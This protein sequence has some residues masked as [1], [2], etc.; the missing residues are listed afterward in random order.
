MG[1]LKEHQLWGEKQCK[2][3]TLNGVRCEQP[4]YRNGL[5]FYCSKLARKLTTPDDSR[6]KS[7]NFR[8]WGWEK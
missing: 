7:V 3:Q 6:M 4:V 1:I 2:S 5:C 8:V